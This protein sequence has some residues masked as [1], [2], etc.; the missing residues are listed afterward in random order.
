MCASDI[1]VEG[2]LPAYHLGEVNELIDAVEF[3][4]RDREPMIA[5]TGQVNRALLRCNAIGGCYVRCWTNAILPMFAP[6]SKSGGQR[7]DIGP[8]CEPVIQMHYGIACAAWKN[9]I[10]QYALA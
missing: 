4:G 5:V 2:K 6:L 8:I 3:A 7:S 10:F 1:R 9:A